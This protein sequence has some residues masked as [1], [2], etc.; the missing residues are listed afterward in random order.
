MSKWLRANKNICLSGGQTWWNTGIQKIHHP[1]ESP[2]AMAFEIWVPWI[3]YRFLLNETLFGRGFTGFPEVWRTKHRKKRKG[4]WQRW[5]NGLKKEMLIHW[6]LE[7]DEILDFRWCLESFLLE[8]FPF[9]LHL[10]GCWGCLLPNNELQ[11]SATS[12]TPRVSNGSE[13]PCSQGPLWMCTPSRRLQLGRV[14]FY[15][16]IS[17]MAPINLKPFEIIDVLKVAHYYAKYF[18]SQCRKFAQMDV[19]L[20]FVPLLKSAVSTYKY[21]RGCWNMLCLLWPRSCVNSRKI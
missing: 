9:F 18:R 8:G 21:Y 10:W 7:N 4:W 5:A 15:M 17:I 19:Q 12:S 1:R 3:P 6:C 14:G 13:I 20:D 11:G 2:K 16:L